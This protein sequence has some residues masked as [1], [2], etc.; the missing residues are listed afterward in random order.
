MPRQ[1][2]EQQSATNAACLQVDLAKAGNKCYR[3]SRH[4]KAVMLEPSFLRIRR[5]VVKY[6]EHQGH[7]HDISRRPIALATSYFDRYCSLDLTCLDDSDLLNL[8]SVACLVTATKM[9][10]VMPLCLVSPTV[11]V[12]ASCTLV[13]HHMISWIAS[14]A[15]SLPL[16]RHLKSSS[17]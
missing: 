1:T 4:G 14:I 9:D 17:K 11:C 7:L 5:A 6:F 16:W 2:L 10:K 12:T 13:K 15:P 8:V 3:L